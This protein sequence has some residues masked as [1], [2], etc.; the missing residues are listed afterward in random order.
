[1]KGIVAVDE[2]WGIGK[3]NGL[4]FGI[5][6]DMK[7]FRETTKN[8]VVVM[9][10]NTLRSLPNG[11][12]LKNRVNIVLSKTLKRDDCIVVDGIES[13][14]K[15]LK[16]YD[17]DDVY[18]I[19]GAKIYRLLLDYCEEILV[20]KVQ[21]DGQADVFFE[22]LDEKSDW[23]LEGTTENIVSDGYTITFN[24]YKNLKVKNI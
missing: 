6:E 20:T 4:L 10:S 9:G 19:G 23:K 17:T 11:N 7:F 14:A 22:N 13:L 2:K 24:R 15:E 12:P 1:M 16:E 18:V 21:A 3:D 8:K 5:R